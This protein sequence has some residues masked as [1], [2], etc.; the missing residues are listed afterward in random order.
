MA[1]KRKPREKL[2][3][4]TGPGGTR[5]FKPGEQSYDPNP[6]PPKGFKRPDETPRTRKKGV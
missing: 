2:T 4:H 5:L 1:T 3:E 6:P